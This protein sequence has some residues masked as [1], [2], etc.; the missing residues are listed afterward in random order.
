MSLLLEGTGHSLGEVL[1]HAIGFPSLSQ[2]ECLTLPRE[3]SMEQGTHS[4]PGMALGGGPRMRLQPRWAQAGTVLKAH[5]SYLRQ[6][7]FSP[8]SLLL[9]TAVLSTSTRFILKGCLLSLLPPGLRWPIHCKQRG[10]LAALPVCECEPL[11]LGSWADPQRESAPW[12]GQAVPVWDKAPCDGRVAKCWS[13]HTAKIFHQPFLSLLVPL[14]FPEGCS[15]L[16]SVLCFLTSSL[17]GMQLGQSPMPPRSFH[18]VCQR[19]ASWGD[20]TGGGQR[21]HTRKKGENP[22]W[23]PTMIQKG[24]RFHSE[25]QVTSR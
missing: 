21:P 3:S 23:L 1:R 5:C 6:S 12:L 4:A 8:P 13:R 2:K 20:G 24:L 22:Q 15:L 7:L 25:P 16:H 17:S 11:C 9:G 14:L 10:P 19:P 18:R